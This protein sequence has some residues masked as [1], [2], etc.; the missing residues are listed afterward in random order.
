M[1]KKYKNNS[2]QRHG[3]RVPSFQ[4]KQS[5]A[6]FMYRSEKVRLGSMVAVVVVPEEVNTS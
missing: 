3:C 6:D 1:P 2:K 5:T 4:L